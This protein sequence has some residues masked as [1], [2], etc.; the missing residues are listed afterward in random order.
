M[1]VLARRSWVPAHSEAFVQSRAAHY[2]KSDAETLEA[3]LT[4]LIEQNRQIH[5]EQCI[6]LN[7]ATNVMN[8]KAE[9]ILAARLGSRPSLGYPADKY[10][11]GLEAIEQIEILASQLACEIFNADYAEIRVAAGAMANLYAFMSTCQ[12]GDSI[13]AP[14]AA[15]GG[16]ITHHKAGAAGLFGLNIHAAPI[17]P[18]GYTVDVKALRKQAQEIQP[19]LITIGGSLNLFAHPIQEIREIA[20]EVGAYLLFDAAHMSGMIA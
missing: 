16:H 11:M 18:E 2:A 20:D 8:P 15:I 4:R 5:E 1:K 12:P 7:P 9:A 3:E 10:E 13:I 14:S 17:E 6:N 19:K